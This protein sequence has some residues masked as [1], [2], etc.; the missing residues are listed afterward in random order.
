MSTTFRPLAEVRDAAPELVDAL[1]PVH[2][3]E[4]GEEREA[5]FAFRYSVYVQEIG[6][7]GVSADHT[8]RLA[9]DE[10]D[11]KP[12]TVLLYTTDDEGGITGTVRLRKWNPGGVPDADRD[13]F[14]MERFPGIEALGVCE[15]GRLAIDPA[16]RGG[17]VPVSLV[18]ALYQLMVESDTAVTFN[19]CPPGLVRYYRMIGYRTYDG[20]LVS[21]P[22]GIMVPLVSVTSD[23]PDDASLLAPFAEA[24]FGQGKRPVVDIS[25][26]A[27][28]LDADSVP[29][30]FD[31]SAT[32]ERV[33]RLRGA[34]AA[35]PTIL[36]TLSEDTVRKLSD[37]GFVLR[38]RAGQVLIEKG[39]AQQEVFIILEGAFEARDGDRRLGVV[40]PG[41]VV[42]EVAFFGSSKRRSASVT[43]ASDGQVLVLRRRFI[44]ELM[45]T[46]PARG[47]EI[48]FALAQALA[49]RQYLTAV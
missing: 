36:Q 20:R 31:Q 45:T 24:F 5:I 28:V 9:H 15:A 17:L 13:A 14:S 38:V 7:K 10:E 33:R 37:K 41:D 44:D 21:T 26:W 22:E 42:G 40:G 47:A 8:R 23:L 4:S 29:V 25:Q 35:S 43:A 48:L 11:D 32:W 34:S 1:Q 19:C 39:L 3:A 6:Y 18:C 49:D 2:V 46:E 27:E 30:S 16:Q 12:Y